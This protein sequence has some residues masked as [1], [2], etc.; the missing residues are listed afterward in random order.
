MDNVTQFWNYYTETFGPLSPTE[1]VG[2]YNEFVRS[3]DLSILK[4]VIDQLATDEG[5]MGKPRL[6]ALKSRYW[7]IFRI[8]TKREERAPIDECG[9]CGGTGRML[10]FSAGELPGTA[11]LL[12]VGQIPDPD[13]DIYES[14][15]PC[16]CSRGKRMQQNKQKMVADMKEGAWAYE[17]STLQRLQRVCGYSMK[18]N[19]DQIR[20]G[21]AGLNQVATEPEPSPYTSVMP[22][23]PNF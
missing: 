15:M 12:A 2:H 22:D 23:E 4:V 5:R 6:G 20:N 11:E 19:K 18:T 7:K 13:H 10:L 21:T 1:T 9:L 16:R 17:D 8:S 14:M 3:S